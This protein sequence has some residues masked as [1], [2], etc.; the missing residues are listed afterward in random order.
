MTYRPSG[1][2]VKDSN[3]ST[4][5]TLTASSTYTGTA[6]DTMAY[7]QIHLVM[8]MEPNV[9]PNGDANTAAGS[10][11]VEFSPDATN[12]DISVPIHVRTGIFIPQTYVVVD[13]YFRVRYIN[14][15]GASAITD[16]GTGETADTARNQTA[17]RLN[18]YLLYTG[19]KELGRTIDQSVSGSDPVAL[20]RSVIMGKV[21]GTAD[22][23]KNTAVNEAGGFQ[24]SDYGMEVSRGNL[25]DR[26]AVRI[27]ARNPSVSTTEQ[28]IWNGG[29][30]YNFLTSASTVRIRSGG[31]ANDTSAGS[32]AREV[33]VTGLDSSG[34]VVS[35]AIAT[36]GASASSSTTA[37]FQRVNSVEVTQAGTYAT[38]AIA[39]GSNVGTI[40]LETTGGTLLAAIPANTGQDAIAV[41]TVPNSKKGY[42][43]RI[44]VTPEGNKNVTFRLWT[45]ENFDDTSA[46]LAP[47]LLRAEWNLIGQES[48][49]NLDHPFELAGKTD[50]W[51]SANTSSG[52]SAASTAF[53][54]EV[55]DD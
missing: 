39:T 41:Y 9:V 6:T 16:L 52:T 24:I 51:V 45:R 4:T 3:N 29:A 34:D 49:F 42:F 25:G 47:K 15:G 54:I 50:V 55:V 22:N 8:Y 23:Y 19:T 26:S 32:G 36:N 21:S 53:E 13:R 17:F 5:S 20:N 31:N 10:L 28:V 2:Y 38:G 33:T 7:N 48:M 40:T 1:G 12:W 30:A 35:E 43:R 37:T 14:D 44:R 27:A 11:Y 18:S 46:P